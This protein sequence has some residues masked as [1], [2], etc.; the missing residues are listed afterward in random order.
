MLHLVPPSGD[1]FAVISSFRD[2]LNVF[3]FMDVL[4]IMSWSIWMARNDFIFRGIQPNMQFVSDNFK[5]EFA[6][7]TFRAKVSKKTPNVF[8]GRSS[9]VICMIFFVSFFVS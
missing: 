9:T 4:I 1:P 8:M 7:V 2:Q 3:F 6:L 5:R